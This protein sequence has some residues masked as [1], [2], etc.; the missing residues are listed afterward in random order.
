MNQWGGNQNYR[1]SKKSSSVKK[2]KRSDAATQVVPNKTERDY[3]VGKTIANATNNARKRNLEHIAA[4][5]KQQRKN[6]IVVFCVLVIIVAVGIVLSNY[7]AKKTAE[8][9]A[10]LAEKNPIT[11]TVS[12]VDENVGNNVSERV[13][14]FVARI[15][16]D[17]KEYNVEIDHVVLPFQK[18]REI[19]VYF[20][21]RKEYYKMTMER[22][23][24]V[25]V[26]DAERMMRYLDGKSLK[27]EYVDLRVEGK[28][29]YK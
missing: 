15:E 19:I 14:V 2:A 16:A 13:K 24:A 7:V 8:H 5:K 1:P 28:A 10:S 11:P 29:Y 18:A 23:S 21:D 9:Q 22:G 4:R 12:I 26:E 27:P 25:Q 17:A 20:K 3:R 6:V